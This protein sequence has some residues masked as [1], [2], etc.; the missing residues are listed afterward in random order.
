MSLTSEPADLHIGVYVGKGASHSWTWFADF[1][2]NYAYSKVSFLDEARFALKA[3]EQNVL[4]VSGGD[5]FAV[6]RALGPGGAEALRRFLDRGGLYMGSCAGAYLPLHSSKEGLRD[7]N[8]VRSRINNLTRDL[9]PAHRLPLKFSNK[10]GCAYIYHPVRETVRVRMTE[11]VPVWG[12]REIRVPLYGG[13]PM[14]PSEDILPR[15]YYTGFTDQTLY[16]T[17]PEIGERVYLGKVAACEKRIGEGRMVLLGPHF[18]HPGFPEGNDIIHQWIL[19]HRGMQG[20][21]FETRPRK[22]R[23]KE[24][25]PVRFPADLLRDLKLEFSNMRIRANALARESVSW[26]IGAKV[27]EPEKIAHFLDAVWKRLSRMRALTGQG[28]ESTE[29]EALLERAAD[30]HRMIKHLAAR[31]QRK[32]E[33]QEEAEKLFAVLR[34]LVTNFLQVYFYPEGSVYEDESRVGVT[35]GSNEHVCTS[36]VT[37]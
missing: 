34:E 14:Q 9:P 7:F 31:I 6:A 27:Y 33:S 10:Y 28:A 32:E 5:T 35:G 8:F 3:H 11:D 12:G 26:H 30:C 23:R 16:L 15:A 22:K 20:A 18:E 36:T 17:D 29:G 21:C 37:G 1:L 25:G 24:A 4:L 19:Q 2:E 13:P